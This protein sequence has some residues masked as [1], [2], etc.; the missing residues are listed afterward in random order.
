MRREVLPFFLQRVQRRWLSLGGGGGGWQMVAA[1][2]QV[3]DLGV[4][5]LRG[6]WVEADFSSGQLCSFVTGIAFGSLV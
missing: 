4:A 5:L 3:P 6:E 2:G 1:E